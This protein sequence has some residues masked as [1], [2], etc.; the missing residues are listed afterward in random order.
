MS[1]GIEIVGPLTASRGTKSETVSEF[2]TNEKCGV[3]PTQL[4][5][6]AGISAP[7]PLKCDETMANN[8]RKFRRGWQN[9]AVIARLEKIDEA[10]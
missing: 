3:A 6:P 7:K 9:Y 10:Y 2:R 1:Y 4:K 8:W 5:V